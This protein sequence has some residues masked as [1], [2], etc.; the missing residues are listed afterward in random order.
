M[1]SV[2][3]FTQIITLT[4]CR[5]VFWTQANI[6]KTLLK[7]TL[8]PNFCTAQKCD[9]IRSFPQFPADLVTFTEEILNGKLYFLRSVG[10]VGSVL[11]HKINNSMWHYHL[12]KVN[13]MLK[14]YQFYLI[15]LT[16]PELNDLCLASSSFLNKILS[17]FN[18]QT[19]SEKFC[20][21]K[22]CSISNDF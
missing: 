12:P 2:R 16:Q 10:S 1:T 21:N 5:F 11:F 18:S 20:A 9:Q 7:H 8:L 17:S 14:I 13:L 4:F 22:E 19:L 3:F 15:F 6:T